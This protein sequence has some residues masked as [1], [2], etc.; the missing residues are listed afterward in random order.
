M[1]KKLLDLDLGTLVRI[2]KE[3]VRLTREKHEYDEEDER[4][5]RSMLKE[6]ESIGGRGGRAEIVEKASLLVF[7]IS[8]GQY[9]HDGNKRTALVAGM[10][11][12][13][14]NGYRMNIEDGEL[15][16][17]LDRAG[18][19]TATLNEVRSIMNRLIHHV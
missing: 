18:V 7:R 16:P 2:N 11:F 17:V 10:A 19:S 15:V 5:M 9:F 12:L 6:I 8:S 3:V 4:R 14:M 1:A 13:A